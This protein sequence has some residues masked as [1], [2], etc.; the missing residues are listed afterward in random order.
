MKSFS[1]LAL[2]LLVFTS[3]QDNSKWIKNQGRVFGTFYHLTYESPEGKDLQNKVLAAL[4]SVNQS[5]STYDS[6]SVISLF[7]RSDN[8][9][10][11]DAHFR[12]VFSS[13]QDI[14]RK[15]NGAFDMTVAPLVNAWGFGFTNRQRMTPSTIDSLLT[16]IGMEHVEMKEDFIYKD[17][18]E[19]ML[20][21][22]AI[23]K[24]YGVDVAASVLERNGCNNYLVEIGGEVTTKG[25]NTR[26]TKWRVGID[27]PIDDPSASNR[28]IQLIIGLSGQ[29]LAT[30]GNYRQFYIDEETGQK[31]AH[32]INPKTGNP[33]DHTLLSASIISDDCMTADAFAT[34]CMVM[35]LDK[36]L[37]L[38]KK[39][40]EL[41]GCFIYDTEDGM[42]VTW[43]EGFD[44]YI[45]E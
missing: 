4:D 41:D 42:N 31:Y 34:A 6:T 35:G 44:K 3:C 45:V 18:K 12:N 25:L 33:V 10:T 36:S 11:T 29:A 30:S 7:N 8:K 21:A 16:L 2:I 32:T 20:D 17:K 43:T 22:S 23:A 28:E 24:G 37:E 26:N 1:I 38:L 40:P 15:T 19:V 13:A 14:T 39:H 9:A 27:R 5:L